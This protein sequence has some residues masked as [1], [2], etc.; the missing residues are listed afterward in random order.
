MS[1]SEEER[2]TENAMLRHNHRER[3]PCDDVGRNWSDSAAS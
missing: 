2:H 3:R 1:L